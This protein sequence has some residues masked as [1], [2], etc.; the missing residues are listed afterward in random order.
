MWPD[1]V[2]GGLVTASGEHADLGDLMPLVP[3]NPVHDDTP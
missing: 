3:P 2:A 1:A